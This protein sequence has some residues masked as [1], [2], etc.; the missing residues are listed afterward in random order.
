[1]G[2][3][4]A[5]NQPR[6]AFY[7]GFAGARS[8]NAECFDAPHDP[9]ARA[10]LRPALASARAE[11]AESQTRSRYAESLGLGVTSNKNDKNDKNEALHAWWRAN[12][13]QSTTRAFDAPVAAAAARV[14]GA[15]ADAEAKRRGF[16][17]AAR[18][19]RLYYGDLLS[20]EGARRVDA[21]LRD[22]PP[23]EAVEVFET[24]RAVHAGT[25]T[26]RCRTQSATA[27]DFRQGFVPT[28]ADARRRAET[29]RRAKR[30]RAPPEDPA[31]TRARVK[32]KAEMIVEEANGMVESR[33]RREL[34]SLKAPTLGV[35]RDPTS[36]GVAKI[37]CTDGALACF[38]NDFESAEVPRFASSY[39]EKQCAFM[40]EIV[41]QTRAG[42]ASREARGEGDDA[43][44]RGAGRAPKVSR[45]DDGN[46]RRDPAI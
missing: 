22:A 34:L 45:R 7:G 43:L 41:A 29:A 44:R 42:G 2:I 10:L 37:S 36:V 25:A 30:A 19:T 23:E 38:G 6:R 13:L 16:V 40:S 31:V 9:A 3:D 32:R 17:D 20:D 15:A 35:S 24:L 18:G 14:P 1:M 46:R 12:A 28:E 33:N 8:A 11:K 39:A 5:T 27:A 21:M 4:P 26:H